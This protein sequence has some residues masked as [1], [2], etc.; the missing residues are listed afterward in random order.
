MYAHDTDASTS[1]THT[2]THTQHTHTLTSVFL[3][4]LPRRHSNDSQ[5]EGWTRYGTLM[6]STTTTTTATILTT[7]L[8]MGTEFFLQNKLFVMKT[9]LFF[10]F[11]CSVSFHGMMYSLNLQ[12]KQTLAFFLFQTNKQTNKQNSN[13]KLL[14][15]PE[16][17]CCHVILYW[18]QQMVQREELQIIQSASK[19]H[20]RIMRSHETLWPHLGPHVIAT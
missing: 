11:K 18:P 3:I 8:Y 15:I 5:H 6:L 12:I 20:F 10:Q 1:N 19:E 9:F 2:H 16:T 14:S 4:Q 7:V 17:T 13:N